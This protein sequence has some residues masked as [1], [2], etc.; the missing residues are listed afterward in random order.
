M[1]DEFLIQLEI[2]GK[3]YPLRIPRK[4]EEIMRK[5]AKELEKVYDFYSASY[6]VED[7]EKSGR[8]LMAMVAFQL[9]LKSLEAENKVDLLPFVKRIETLSSEV[10]QYLAENKALL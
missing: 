7:I 6:D 2:L 3:K 10:T 1:N 9:A 8:E 5:A 4:D